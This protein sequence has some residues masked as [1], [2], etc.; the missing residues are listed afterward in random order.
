MSEASPKPDRPNAH[1]NFRARR[2]DDEMRRVI[3]FVGPEKLEA[4]LNG[5]NDGDSRE[6]IRQ[7]TPSIQILNED[8][9]LGP[10]LWHIDRTRFYVLGHHDDGSW[11]YGLE[12]EPGEPHEPIP[13]HGKQ[14]PVDDWTEREIALFKDLIRSL[15]AYGNQVPAGAVHRSIGPMPKGPATKD[16]S[17]DLV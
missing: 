13:L 6:I 4:W 3:G 14:K 17:S 9:F 2:I 1:D 8:G 7:I 16:V 12:P 15:Q 10:L 5:S 11:T